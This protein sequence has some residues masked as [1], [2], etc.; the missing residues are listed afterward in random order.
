[1]LIVIPKGRLLGEIKS[2]LSSI[3]INFDDSSRKLILDTSKRY[4]SFE[5]EYIVKVHDESE[6]GAAGRPN[7]LPQRVD[8][9]ELSV[10][11]DLKCP[12]H[13]QFDKTHLALPWEQMGWQVMHIRFPKVKIDG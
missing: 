5:Y 13:Y 8:S 7:K 1:M 12:F 6:G 3:G 10:Q 11:V 9:E 2:L 4:D